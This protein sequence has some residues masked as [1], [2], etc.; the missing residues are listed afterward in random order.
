MSSAPRKHAVIL[1]QL[2]LM[3]P[4]AALLLLVLGRLIVDAIY[5]QRVA[6]QHTDLVAVEED[7]LRSLQRDAW[8]ATAYQRTADTLLLQT[9]TSAGVAQVSYTFAPALVQRSLP[10]G[11]ERYW[12]AAR[13]NFA[14]RIEPGPRADVLWLNL[15]ELPAP[16]QSPAI[17]RDYTATVLLPH[18]ES[19]T[20]PA[21]T[22]TT[23]PAGEVAP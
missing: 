20:G 13:L 7:L 18:A 9:V 4:I 17:P 23:A 6:A 1:V 21:A 8:A 22:T 5:I 2:L 19:V 14:W 15:H 10:A 3:L 16:R 12:R 11:P